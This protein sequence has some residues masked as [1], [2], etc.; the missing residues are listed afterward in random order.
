MNFKA[1]LE[2]IE[3]GA[4][5]QLDKF[6]AQAKYKY[7]VGDSWSGQKAKSFPFRIYFS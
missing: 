3:P 2:G 1:M 6:L 7:Q 5:A 4:G